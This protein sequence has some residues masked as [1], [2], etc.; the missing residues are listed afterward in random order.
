VPQKVSA[1]R[2]LVLEILRAR[3]APAP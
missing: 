1:F 3:A 2:D